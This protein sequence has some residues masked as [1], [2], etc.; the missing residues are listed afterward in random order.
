VKNISAHTASAS[1][2]C[3]DPLGFVHWGSFPNA[4]FRVKAEVDSG[5]SG[6]V[7]AAVK[8]SVLEVEVDSEWSGTNKA[9]VEA[10]VLKVK[11]RF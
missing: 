11:S 6:E 7:K 3:A 2:A 4:R 5:W 8:A 10:S 9:A 1:C